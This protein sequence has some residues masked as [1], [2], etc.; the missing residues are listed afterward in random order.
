MTTWARG[1]RCIWHLKTAKRSTS[2]S[3]VE[4]AQRACTWRNMT[5]DTYLGAKSNAMDDKYSD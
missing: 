2:A 4:G 5:C 3:V 1:M